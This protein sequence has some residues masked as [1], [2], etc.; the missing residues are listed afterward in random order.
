MPKI[1]AGEKI[2]CLAITEPGGGSDVANLLTTAKREG[3][4]YV[5]NGKFSVSNL[6]KLFRQVSQSQTF[7]FTDFAPYAP[8]NGGPAAFVAQLIMHKGEAE[9]VVALRISLDAI[10]AIK[11]QRDGMGETGETYLVGEDLL[12][13]SDPFPDPENHTVKASCKNPSR[14]KVDTEPPAAP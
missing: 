13:R 5:V 8:S 9:T 4:H 6:G 12:L 10:N 14:G 11:T 3:D 1:L 2:S 7:G